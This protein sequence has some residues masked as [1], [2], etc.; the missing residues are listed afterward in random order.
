MSHLSTYKI[1]LKVQSPA[2]LRD[3]IRSLGDKLHLVVCED[4]ISDY[5]G[6]KVSCD[7]G[8]SG[9]GLQY[10]IGFTVD[11]DGNVNVI[12]DASMQARF[13]EVAETA[14]NYINAYQSAR[15][16]R[17]LYPLASTNIQIKAKRAI[18]EVEIP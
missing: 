17:E 10:G 3:A 6:T 1:G 7:I 14:K 2:L 12:G 5:Y 16:A 13:R 11:K 9:I 4:H 18:L 8:L 15:K